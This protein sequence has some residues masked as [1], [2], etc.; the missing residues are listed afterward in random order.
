[1]VV[2]VAHQMMPIQHQET[3]VPEVLE[4]AQ[5]AAAEDR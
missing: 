3:V 1:M 4:A 2:E 5:E